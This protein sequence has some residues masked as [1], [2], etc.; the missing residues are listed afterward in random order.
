MI[1]TSQLIFEYGTASGS[2]TRT[3]V[4]A[5]FYT[6][7]APADFD[8]TQKTIIFHIETEK[9]LNFKT[10]DNHES[11]VVFKC[12]GGSDSYTDAR[13]VYRAVH[14]R[15]SGIVNGA[16]TVGT[17]ISSEMLTAFLGAP[18]R[19]DSGRTW[20]VMIAKFLVRTA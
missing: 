19:Q 15:F 5:R 3:Q 7:V 9:D 20:P 18:E 8:N 4:G 16:G 10:V 1:D 17:I 6:P 2:A 14:D 13:T 12:Y 11:V